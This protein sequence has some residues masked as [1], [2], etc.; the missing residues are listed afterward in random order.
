MHLTMGTVKSNW[1]GPTLLLKEQGPSV[2]AAQMVRLAPD[3]LAWDSIVF[4]EVLGIPEH[5]DRVI[6]LQCWA[7]FDL[8]HLD[9]VSLCQKQEGFAI[10]LLHVNK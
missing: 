1:C 4:S 9:D 2:A 7:Q 3:F 5:E 10:N 6:D 8:H